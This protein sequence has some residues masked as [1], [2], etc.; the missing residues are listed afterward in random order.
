MHTDNGAL[1][2]ATAS[3]PMMSSPHPL[4][5]FLMPREHPS[6]IEDFY[7]Q[8]NGRNPESSSPM[9]SPLRQLRCTS[10]HWFGAHLTSSGLAPFETVGRRRAGCVDYSEHL[11][12]DGLRVLSP[13]AAERAITWSSWARLLN[14]S[15]SE[16]TP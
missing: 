6:A 1:T 2:C 11:L 14:V 13:M 4:F 10:D 15:A 8:F 5:P 12:F 9:V 16:S 3:F 7:A